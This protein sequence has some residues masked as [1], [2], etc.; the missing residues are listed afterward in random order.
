MTSSRQRTT[1]F[2]VVSA[3]LL[4]SAS[5]TLL[6]GCGGGASNSNGGGASAPMATLTASP[7]TISSGQSS[8]L[9]WTTTNA[10]S[11]QINNGV[12]S[13]QVGSGN[14]IAGGLAW[15]AQ[16]NLYGTAAFA[17]PY[18]AGTVFELT[19]SAGWLYTQLAAFSGVQGPVD[20]PT[21]DSAGNVYVSTY[22]TVDL[23]T[24]VKLTQSQGTWTSTVLHEF[25]G[26]DGAFPVG[27]VVIDAQGNVYGTTLSGGSYGKGVIFQIT[28]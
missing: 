4:I 9:S 25:D 7:A 10:N 13:V 5:L 6:T 17:G 11:A 18:G 27:S 15:D 12:G 14:D 16:G 2:V 28:P 8:T 1:P 22:H 23:G 21:L 24:L 3:F 19:P 20:T 26:Y